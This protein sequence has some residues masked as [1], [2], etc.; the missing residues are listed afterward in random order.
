MI[1][2]IDV[3]NSFIK[4][5]R[6]KGKNINR[7]HRLLTPAISTP[8]LKTALGRMLRPKERF[9]VEAIVICSVVPSAT[10]KLK[11]YLRNNVTAKVYE[12]T[13]ELPIAIKNLYRNPRQV[14]QDRLV[15]AFAAKQNYRLPCV[16]VDFGTALTF[17]IISR[18]GSYAGGLIFPG[19]EASLARLISSAALLPKR[20]R[21]ASPPREFPG[22]DTCA[23]IN[24][25][26][27]WGYSCLIDGVIGK[28][29][30][31]LKSRPFVVATG[32]M[33]RLIAPYCKSIDEINPDLTF[34]G[35]RLIYKKS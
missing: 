33:S 14:G 27:I 21:L 35:L 32:G 23:S 4:F 15:N 10:K 9:K 11:S 26:V 20:F 5:A 1:I 2:T 18:N 17:D 8:T 19:L 6:F 7:Q 34:E 28:I 31:R 16:I 29:S 25:G 22:K 3:G 30:R 24:A 12:V 13:K